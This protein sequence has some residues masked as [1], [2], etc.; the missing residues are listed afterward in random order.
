MN[1]YI[2]I[3]GHALLN[4]RDAYIVQNIIDYTTNLDGIIGH[5]VG[6]LCVSKR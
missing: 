3:Y 2:F 1:I 4:E 6:P 5:L